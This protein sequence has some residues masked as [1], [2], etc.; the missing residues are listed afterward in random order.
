QARVFIDGEEKTDRPVLLAKEK[1]N[2]VVLELDAPAK[3]GEYKLTVRIEPL[4]GEVSTANNEITTYLTVTKDGVSVLVVDRLRLEVKFL[5]QA[6]AADPRFRVS[7]SVRQTDAPA[8]GDAE[9]FDFERQPYDV[10]ILGD[11]AA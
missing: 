6:L 2:D 1:G 3:P 7:E 8:P 11:V 9:L 10:V 4:P 5:R